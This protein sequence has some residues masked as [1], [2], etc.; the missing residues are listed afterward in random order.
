[1]DK[2][3]TV[4]LF[5]EFIR[6]CV[7]KMGLLQKE[8]AACCG[9]TLG[10][11]HTLVEID[12]LGSLSLNELSDLLSLDKSTMSRTVDSLVVSGLVE[13]QV[14]AA[15]R[16]YTRSSLTENGKAMVQGINERM[17][18]YFSRVLAAVP[19]EKRQAAA[20]IMPYLLAGVRDAWWERTDRQE[21][22]G[23]C[24]CE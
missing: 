4:S 12:R 14:D 18:E 24:G 7:R 2:Q 8:D 21:G 9:I 1:M 5:R 22:K 17:D 11:C 3:N 16:R 15:D 13:R 6:T 10:Q 23:G 19:E 20:E